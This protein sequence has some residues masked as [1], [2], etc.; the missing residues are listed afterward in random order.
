M[1]KLKGVL[2]LALVIALFAPCLGSEVMIKRKKNKWVCVTEQ[3]MCIQMTTQES[4]KIYQ[5][6][7]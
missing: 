6:L 4:A 2:V 5:L 1:N 7:S 3:E